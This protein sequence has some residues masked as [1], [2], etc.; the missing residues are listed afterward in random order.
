MELSVNKLSRDGPEW[1]REGETLKVP[2]D[3]SMPE[4][5]ISEMKGKDRRLSHSLLVTEER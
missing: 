3:T 1:L 5:C 2:E 4:E